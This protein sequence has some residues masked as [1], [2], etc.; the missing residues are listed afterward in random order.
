MSY[1]CSVNLV[2]RLLR[3]LLL[4]GFLFILSGCHTSRLIPDDGYLLTGT[5]I[6]SEDK[7]ISTDE[8]QAY[9]PQRPN[10]KW[11]SLFK[12]PLGI[13]SLSGSDSTKRFNRFLRHLGEAPVIYDRERT[14]L[15]CNNMQLAV[16][17]QGYLNA[18]VLL[19]EK[20]KKNKMKVFYR[21]VP[22]ER[23]HVRNFSLDVQDAS[24]ARVLDSLGYQ[25]SLAQNAER[26][27]PYSINELDAERS[28]LYGLLVEN[29][30]YKFNK[31]YVHFRVDTT[32]GRHLADVE[33]I[34]RQARDN[35]DSTDL[36]H[37]QYNIGNI[38]YDFGDYK[39]FLRHKVLRNATAITT[40]GLYREKDMHE[41]Y[42]RMTRLSAVM[43]SNVRIKERD[44]HS[45]T[46]DV[47]ISLTPSKR[48]SFSAELEG[49]NS[50]GD[51]GAAASLTYQNRN[52]FRGSELFNIKVR[53]A[54]EAIK[55]L[56]GYADQNFIEYSVESG[57]VF[58]D[59]K[60]PFLR[61]SFRRN[62]QATTEINFAY[63]SQDRPEFHRRVL[64][65][66]LRYRW[67]RM[68]K[69]LQHR[70]DLLNLDYVFM[71]WISDTF[72]EKYLS[73]PQNRNAILKYNYENLFIMNWAYHFSYTSRPLG[74]SASNYG[75]NAY[76]IRL[77]LETAGNLLY[78]I[79]S[80]T[81]TQ[82]NAEGKYTLFNIAYAQ[83]A[84]FDFAFCKSFLINKNNSL[85]LHAALGVAFPY[86]NSTILPYEKR[87]FSGGANSV[88][89]WSV[90]ELGPGRFQGTDGRIDFINQTGDI[91]LD[92]NAEYRTHL[93]WK[94]DAAAFIDAG[95][96]WTI[97]E[98]KEQPGGQFQFDEFW[99]QIAV[100]YGLGLRLNFNFFILRFDAGM[101]AV[102]PAYTDSHRHFPF[103]H[104]K[105][106]RD[107]TFH[108]AVGMP[109]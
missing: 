94:F 22:H 102:N 9:M 17:N 68:N 14:I 90:R 7:K 35:A 58:P 51:F 103:T 109:F 30:Y 95:N 1:L 61:P 39:P 64:T 23:Y 62:A 73:D 76:T 26:A 28:R 25:P 81:K 4:L 60:F 20:A 72:R 77:A 65:G 13:Y 57:L 44:N 21:I 106:K 33:M 92:L 108:F 11:F 104:P 40:G 78:G 74:A 49:T 32:L 45:D 105:M 8:L 6:S 15:A 71:P 86:G 101:K 37:H 82:Q 50:A 84:K 100:S 107:F 97:R 3:P 19:L 99:K 36:A 85:A 2:K 93:F 16:R 38:T 27:K 34:V 10:N 47:D 29:G 31:D 66:V 53:G 83:Y 18:E 24:L 52:L 59:F 41:T 75:T 46:L 5:S 70:F 87:Y 55:G 42:A 69:Q 63:D 56:S 98:Y 67:T 79:T 80:G 91:K 48:N 96:I 54:F 89:G 88:R 12:V 43:A